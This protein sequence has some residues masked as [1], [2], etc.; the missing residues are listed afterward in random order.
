MGLDCFRLIV[1]ASTFV[2]CL[3]LG[4]ILHIEISGQFISDWPLITLVIVE[5]TIRTVD[6]FVTFHSFY[7][8]VIIH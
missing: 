2:E 7:H 5:S 3:K 8:Q 6:V 4:D 1:E